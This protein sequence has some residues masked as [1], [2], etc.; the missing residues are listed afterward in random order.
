LISQHFILQ[1]YR[2]I[3]QERKAFV[4]VDLVS[5]GDVAGELEIVEQ[6]VVLLGLIGL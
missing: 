5:G 6:E 4:L 3:R 2:G 1:V